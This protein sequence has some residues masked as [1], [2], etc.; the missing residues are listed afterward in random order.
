[1]MHSSATAAEQRSV[2]K[3]ASRVANHNFHTML[4]DREMTQGMTLK[5]KEEIR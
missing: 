4:R 1:M 2:D 5:N 3:S